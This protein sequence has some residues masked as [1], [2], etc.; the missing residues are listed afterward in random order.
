MIRSRIVFA[1]LFS[2][3][4]TLEVIAASHSLA[5]TEDIQQNTLS[6]VDNICA[7][8]HKE[9]EASPKIRTQQL[10]LDTQQDRKVLGSLYNHRV[11]DLNARLNNPETSESM[12]IAIHAELKHEAEAYKRGVKNQCNALKR[13]TNNTA[14]AF[15]KALHMA[16]ELNQG[17]L[18]ELTQKRLNPDLTTD[19]KGTLDEQI[20]AAEA[21]NQLLLKYMQVGESA[22]KQSELNMALKEFIAEPRMQKLYNLALAG[23]LEQS[24]LDEV[25]EVLLECGHRFHGDCLERFSKDECIIVEQPALLCLVCPTCSAPLSEKDRASL[26]L[27]ITIDDLLSFAGRTISSQLSQQ[28][29]SSFVV[30]FESLLEDP[31]TAMYLE[32]LT[33]LRELV[34]LASVDLLRTGDLHG[35]IAQ[36]WPIYSRA[37]FVDALFR[38]IDNF[39]TRE[40][41]LE[42][43]VANTAANPRARCGVHFLTKLFRLPQPQPLTD[44]P[45]IHLVET[46]SRRNNLD[47][48][49]S[50]GIRVILAQVIKGINLA[51]VDKEFRRNLLLAIGNLSE[52]EAVAPVLQNLHASIFPL[53]LERN[54]QEAANGLANLLLEIV[55][56]N[57][58]ERDIQ[59]NHTV[60]T[61]PA[62]YTYENHYLQNINRV[63]E[64]RTIDLDE[65]SEEWCTRFICSL[66]RGQMVVIG[67]LIMSCIIHLRLAG[68][69]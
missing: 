65:A 17:Q 12:K 7:V 39:Y 33:N 32:S 4:F 34:R 10:L 29:V 44:N 49:L 25:H 6:N 43:L 40:K 60:Q 55:R 23:Y 61:H 41:F 28:Q 11:K 15:R 20:T 27:E 50:N 46:L 8:C 54:L 31:Q 5:Q 18:H 42:F 56:V 1:F 38:A 53:R 59:N 37:H 22:A 67:V 64:W 2:L 19:E 24:L 14:K 68:V 26:T 45:L 58:R 47:I 69:V 66:N 21:H 9:M 57:F 63:S 48:L 35:L 52:H 3:L 30:F 62:R 51:A 16:N 36:I 13:I